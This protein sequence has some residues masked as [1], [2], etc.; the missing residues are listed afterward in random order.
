MDKD[1]V[2]KYRMAWVCKVQLVHT[3]Q[4]TKTKKLCIVGAS[5]I[6]HEKMNLQTKNTNSE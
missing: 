4:K 2:E 1:D 3:V 5:M 6:P